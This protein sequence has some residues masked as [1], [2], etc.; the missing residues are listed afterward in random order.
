MT[1]ALSI[2]RRTFLGGVAALGAIRGF[3]I[4]AQAA[5]SPSVANLPARGHVVIRDAYVMTMEPGQADLP[6]GDV[7]VDNGSIVDIGTELGIVGKSGA[8][9]SY[10]GDRLGQGR[11]NSK[12][13]LEEHPALMDTIENEIKNGDAAKEALVLGAIAED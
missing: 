3:G 7:H 2:R 12:K 13:F 10:K 8:F 11:E 5:I 4:G 6:D 9:Y 1:R